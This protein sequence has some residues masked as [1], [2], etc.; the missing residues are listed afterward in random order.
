MLSKG[1]H[2]RDHNIGNSHML[3]DTHQSINNFSSILKLLSN[4]DLCDMLFI[5]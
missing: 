4:Q 2:F 3:T 1:N 5:R